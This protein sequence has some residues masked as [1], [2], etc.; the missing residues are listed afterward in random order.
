M[1]NTARS[2]IAD[3]PLLVWPISDIFCGAQMLVGY[4]IG[5]KMAIN[6][7]ISIGTYMAYA[8]L[9]IWIIFPLRNLGR[10]IVQ[11]SNG[12][13]SYD[14]IYKIIKEDREPLE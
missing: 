9:I 3:H 1:K 7:V 8:G 13:V 6:G 14:R 5:A 12:L 10:M 4:Y 2:Q 11:M